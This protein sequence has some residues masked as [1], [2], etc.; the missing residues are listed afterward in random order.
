MCVNA[1][2]V[3]VCKT[4]EMHPLNILY[5]NVTDMDMLQGDNVNLTAS[6]ALLLTRQKKIL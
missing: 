5:L 6:L 2:I 3:L 4:K 1:Y